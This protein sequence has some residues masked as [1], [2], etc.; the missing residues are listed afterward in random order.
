MEQ[1]DITILKEEIHKI[2]K[3]LYSLEE[4][5]DTLILTINNNV[6]HE[7]SKMGS[8][9]DFIENIYENV[10]HPLGYICNKVT[11]YVN[12]DPLK[13]MS[14]DTITHYKEGEEYH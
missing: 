4:K 5:I 10:K 1:V 2:D 8:H 3:R 13:Q 12:K 14:L 9:I 6:L 11:H 7:C